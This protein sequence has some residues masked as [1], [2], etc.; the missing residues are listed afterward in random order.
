MAL[1]GRS[2]STAPAVNGRL[3]HWYMGLLPVLDLE[4]HP[5]H[6]LAPTMVLGPLQQQASLSAEAAYVQQQMHQCNK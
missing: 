5:G 4:V 1:P 6:W 2:P 3:L